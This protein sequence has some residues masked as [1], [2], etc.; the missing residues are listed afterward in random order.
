MNTQIFN[1]DMMNINYR[2]RELG[3]PRYDSLYWETVREC[4]VLKFSEDDVVA[5]VKWSE[6][7]YENKV[8]S[9]PMF[10]FKEKYHSWNKTQLRFWINRSIMQELEE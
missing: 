9:I 7:I 4:T 6:L 3:F 5:V 8:L 10:E 1:K 2:M